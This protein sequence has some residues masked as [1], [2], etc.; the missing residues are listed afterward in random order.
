MKKIL[1]V[2]TP[3]VLIILDGFGLADFGHAG[4]AITPQTAPRIFSYWEKYPSTTLTAH[5]RDVGLFPG[6]EGNSEA[7]HFNI[8]AGRVVEQ[9]TVRISHAIK[10][11]TFFK[12]E[13][14]LETVRKTPAANAI[15]LVG[16]LTNGQSAHSHP[17]HLYA[18][19]DLM[20]RYKRERVFLH[21]FTDGRDS[22]PHSAISHLRKLRKYMLAHEQIASVCGRFYAMDRNKIWDRTQ[23]AYE[24]MVLGKAKNSANSIEEAIMQAYDRG[25]TDEYITPTVIVKSERPVAVINN[26]DA[27]FFF[28]SRSDR[29]RQLAKALVQPDFTKRNPGAFKRTRWPHD[30]ATV[31]LTDF[32]PELPN[33]LRAFP[34]PDLINCLPKAIGESYRQLYISETEK[35]AHVTYFMNGGYAD[36]VNG[37]VRELVPSGTARSYA[38]EPAMHS[39]QVAERVIDHLAKRTYD[40]VVVNF[41][42]ADMVGH[43]GNLAAAKKAVKALDQQVGRV[44]AAVQKR[45]GQ[46]IITADHGN[47]EA[48]LNP[49]TG[50]VKTEHTTSP[51]PFI[52]INDQLIGQ[53]VRS[54]RLADIAPTFLALLGLHKPK[55]MTG[56]NLL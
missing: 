38:T 12:N 43:T 14:L 6:Q 16:L 49:G 8:G 46:V 21:L 37:E 30:L 2:K 36:P 9:D 34:A 56:K 15:H 40:V 47:A 27:V 33:L 52:V 41:P 54:G 55:E 44:V 24:A 29:A 45:G 48:M 1:E 50:E 7:G 23:V 10:D 26:Q 53:R 17:E 42:N 25:E 35:Y 4:N 11:G 51:V 19:L 31:A 3:A 32:G 20:R 5:G 22:S 13:A 18:L 39:K 28:N